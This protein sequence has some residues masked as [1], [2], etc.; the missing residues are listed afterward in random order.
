MSSRETGGP[1]GLLEPKDIIPRPS[2]PLAN[3]QGE[4]TLTTVPVYMYPLKDNQKGD[5]FHSHIP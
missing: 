4:D 2:K 3:P 1:G 5:T